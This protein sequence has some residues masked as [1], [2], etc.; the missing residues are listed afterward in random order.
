MLSSLTKLQRVLLR[1]AMVF[2][3]FCVIIFF[4]QQHLNFG[5]AQLFDGDVIFILLIVETLTYLAIFIFEYRS[6]IS[7][8]FLPVSFILALA[9]NVLYSIGLHIVIFTGEGISYSNLSEL[10]D[11]FIV[12]PYYSGLVIF[13]IYLCFE[14]TTSLNNLL[15]NRS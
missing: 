9:T 6:L 14:I 3:L 2:N 11:A 15:R 13:L 7:L 5:L 1:L 10:A 4:A 12:A 8:V